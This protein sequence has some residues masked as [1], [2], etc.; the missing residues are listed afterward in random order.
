MSSP[1]D[2][3]LA[4]PVEL[5][6]DHLVSGWRCVI[7]HRAGACSRGHVFEL[8]SVTTFYSGL[9]TGTERTLATVGG[10]EGEDIEDIVSDIL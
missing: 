6:H 4:P 9:S 1:L 10:S 7:S 2:L 5:K 8:P 3:S